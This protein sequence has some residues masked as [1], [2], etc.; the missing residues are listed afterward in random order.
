MKSVLLIG[1]GSGHPEQITLQA[2]RALN[3]ASVFFL[4]DKGRAKAELV[5]LRREI[6]ERYIEQPGY[7]L[8]QVSDPLRED[9][10]DSYEA[11][12]ERWHAQRAGLF[13]RLIDEELGENECGAFLIWG[14]PG[15]YDSTL[16]VLERV[17][18]LGG[19]AFEVEVIPG[20]SSVQALAARHRIPLNR[21][22]EPIRITTGRRLEA[23][24]LDNVVVML[25]AHCAFGQ[26]VDQTLDIYWG[27]YLGTEDELLV[28]GKLH[29]VHGQIRELRE[30][31]RQRKGWIMDTYLLR[32]PLG[33]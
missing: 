18:A 17:V 19:P 21:I 9:D 33:S 1:I 29:E 12:V 3:R 28:S 31:A 14:E 7:R 4:L 15:L 8:V 26:F 32:R 23:A 16:R 2:I 11:G 30:A 6:C 25:D 13:A 10:E 20:I 27:A 5:N 22:G 24:D